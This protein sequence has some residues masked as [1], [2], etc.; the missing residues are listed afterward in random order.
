MAA[1]HAIH[2]VRSDHIAVLIAVDDPAAPGGDTSALGRSLVESLDDALGGFPG[3]SS[4]VGVGSTVRLLTEAAASYRQA[5]NALRVA[6]AVPAVRPL[7]SYDNLGVFRTLLR[8]PLHELRPEDLHPGLARLWSHPQGD[9]LVRTLEAYL[10]LAGDAQ[11][12]SDALVLHRA[13]LYHRLERIEE[14]SGVSL[15]DGQA[16]LELH[17]SLKL[18]RLARLRL[19][20]VPVQEPEPR[21]KSRRSARASHNPSPGAH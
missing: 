5:R 14:I 12:T 6:A 10:D 9:A 4:L 3:W 20:G 8:F 1:G 7:A 18:A 17:L 11:A 16:R 21:R 15:R 2:L 13:S 19:D